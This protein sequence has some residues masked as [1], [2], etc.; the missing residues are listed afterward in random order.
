VPPYLHD[1]RREPERVRDGPFLPRGICHIPTR[2]E[3]CL[4]LPP[5][6]ASSPRCHTHHSQLPA[7][8]CHPGTSED[9][10]QLP[11]QAW[12]TAARAPPRTTDQYLD[13]LGLP[14]AGALRAA[15]GLA[16]NVEDVERFVSLVKMT[17]RDRVVGTGG[18]APRRR[19]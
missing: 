4:L 15:V 9:A 18:L 11:R 19:C 3:P 5:P 1:Y 13:L 10:S 6:P 8:P 7:C 17:Y 16:S 2:R 12:R 14:S